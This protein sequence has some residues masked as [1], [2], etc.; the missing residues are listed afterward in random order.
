MVY[1][2]KTIIAFVLL[3]LMPMQTFPFQIGVVTDTHIINTFDHHSTDCKEH[4]IFTSWYYKSPT[5]TYYPFGHYGCRTPFPLYQSAMA[6]LKEILPNPD[7]ILMCGDYVSSS[8]NVDGI[9]YL[10]V[11][12]KYRIIR[13]TIIEMSKEALRVF[14]DIPIGFVINGNNIFDEVPLWHLL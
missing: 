4:N 9:E 12:S 3:F 7:L 14:S 6:K 11:F 8:D 13:N 1:Y 10:W 2:K 5:N